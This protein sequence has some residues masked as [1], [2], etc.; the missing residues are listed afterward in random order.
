MRDAKGE[1]G[2]GGKELQEIIDGMDKIEEDLVNK[3]LDN[4]M[5]LSIM[6]KNSFYKL[7]IW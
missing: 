6:Q 4:E 5:F 7:T 3:R 2:K 1:Q